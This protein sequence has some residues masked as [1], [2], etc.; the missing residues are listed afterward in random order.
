MAKEVYFIADSI[1]KWDI[2]GFIDVNE[3]APIDIGKNRIPVYSESMVEELDPIQTELAIGIGSSKLMAKIVKRHGSKFNF[4]N[5]IPSETLGNFDD[6]IL[7]SGNIVSLGVVLTTSIKIGSFNILNYGSSVGHDV[8]IGDFNVINPGVNIAGGVKIG[9]ACMLGIGSTILQYKTIG[10]NSII[11]ASCLVNK[12]V[13]SN[14]TVIGVP[15]R[16]QRK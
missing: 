8:E 4:P 15:S 5:L 11:G 14:T 9:N 16:E 7:G 10:D 6:I 3:K 12:D 1:N 13:V 2:H